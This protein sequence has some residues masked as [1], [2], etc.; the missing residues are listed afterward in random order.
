MK[1]SIL[2]LMLIINFY[3]FSQEQNKDTLFI[4]Y[5]KSLLSKFQY[6]GDDNIY[7]RIKGTGNDGF[8][9]FMVNK[10]YTNLKEKKILSFKNVLK[11]SNAYYK[12]GKLADSKLAEYLGKHIIFLIKKKKYINVIVVEEIE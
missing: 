11:K 6:P 2:F 4:E 8:T 5:K 9:Y 12:K 10:V 7:Y 3:S 1:K